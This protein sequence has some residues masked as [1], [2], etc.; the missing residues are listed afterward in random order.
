MKVKNAFLYVLIGFSSFVYAQGDPMRGPLNQPSNGVIDGVVLNDELPVS[1][2]KPYE[3]VRSSDYV[4]S[5]RVYSR[6]DAREKINQSIFL[7][8]DSFDG[9]EGETSSYNPAN[10][11]D[12]DNTSWSRDQSNWSLWTVILRHILLGDLTVYQVASDNYPDVEDGYN[13]RYPVVKN[14]NYNGNDYFLNSAYKKTISNIISANG[15]GEDLK[16]AM[17]SDPE[18]TIIVTKTNQTL[19]AFIDSAIL[20]N[21]DYISIQAIDQEKLA[22]WWEAANEGSIVKK[23]YKMMYAASNSIFAFNVK[24]DWYFDK[25]LSVFEKRIICI[26]PVARY[27]YS[28]LATTTERGDLLV[29]NKLGKAYRFDNGFDEYTE[30]WEEREMFWL[31]FPELRNVIVNYFVYNEKSDADRMSFD[32]LF[33]LRYYSGQIYKSSNRYDQEVQDYRHGVDALYE[34][35]K[36]KDKMRN[37]EHDVWNF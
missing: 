26:A 24:E 27:T 23:D 4:F 2:V 3:F 35:E 6:I 5:K 7:P 8:F 19:S 33:L 10:A 21:P 25:E 11:K 1:M 17:L 32:D 18:D 30:Q 22:S 16:F 36:F 34:A 9:E 37:W 20:A 29:Y 14:A 12:V 31:Y 13:L 15:R 28:D